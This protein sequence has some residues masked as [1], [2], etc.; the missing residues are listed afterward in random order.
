MLLPEIYLLLSTHN[1][2]IPRRKG[3]KKNNARY[4]WRSRRSSLLAAVVAIAI[5]EAAASSLHLLY[6]YG[7]WTQIPI[8]RVVPREETQG[9]SQILV[10][11]WGFFTKEKNESWSRISRKYV[12]VL[13]HCLLLLK[14]WLTTYNYKISILFFHLLFIE[15]HFETRNRQ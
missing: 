6:A 12:Q 8:L 4:S 14:Y 10:N 3:T 5:A 11:L 2:V 9:E 13:T 15:R 1:I 7:F